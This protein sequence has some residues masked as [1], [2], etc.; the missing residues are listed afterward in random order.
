MRFGVQEHHATRRHWDFRLEMGGVLKSWAIPKG[1][2]YDP[3]EKRLAVPVEDHPLDYLEFEGIIPEGNYGAGTVMVWD[4][5]TY[6]VA[7]GDPVRAYERGKLTLVLHGRKLRGEFHL[8]R[9]KLGGQ[10]QWLMFKKRDA[11]AVPGWTL[12]EP[13]V[14]AKTGRTIEQIRA[15][16]GAQWQSGAHAGMRPPSRQTRRG[17]E[18]ASRLLKD[19][20]LDQPGRDPYPRD[21]KPML[22][23]RVATPFDD[24]QWLFEVKW[25]GVR[26]IAYL[27]AEGPRRDVALRSRGG[28]TLNA[29]FPEVVEA[30]YA[31]DLPAAVLDGEVVALDDG[32][33]ANFQLLQSR[34]H[35]GDDARPRPAPVIAYYVFDLLYFNGH[36]LTDRPL[37]ERRKILQAVLRGGSTVRLSDAIPAN[38]RALYAAAQDLGVEG[39]VAK[40]ADSRYEPGI[41][42]RTW[43]KIKVH[44]RMDAVVGGFTRG[45]GARA[46]TFGAVLLGAYTPEGRLQ[47]IGHCGGGFTEADL[48]A[49]TALLLARRDTTCPF[50]QIP[51]TNERATWV[52]PE[53]VIDVE[54][55]GWTNDGLLRVP[56]YKGVRTDKPARE[57]ALESPGTRDRGMA[58][59][60]TTVFRAP[61][62][63]PEARQRDGARRLDPGS[64]EVE[65][66]N[67]DKVFWPERG[68]T[69]GDLIQYYREIAPVIL[70]HLADRPVTLRRFPNG[71]AGE[72]FYQK[73]YPDAPPFAQL[74]SIWTES[75]KKTLAAPVCNNAQ[76]LLWLA[77]LADI[78]IHTW[79]SRISPLRRAERAGRAGTE[80]AASE[81]ALRD[82]VLNRPDY[83]V[84]DIDPYLFPDNKLPQRNGER[85]PDYSRRGFDAAVEAA[86]LLRKVLARLKLEGFVKTSGKTGLHLFVP[87]VRRYTF[88]QTHAF[89]KAVTQY[90]EGLAPTMVTTAWAAEQ[91][92]G[93]VFLDYNQNRLGATLASAYSVRPT[94]EATVSL[95]VAWTELERGLDPLEF[96]IKTVPVLMRK[97][98]DPWRELLARPQLLERHL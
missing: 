16:A 96:T 57:V 7:E 62:P 78:E 81:Q 64:R 19:L 93:K 22:A 41:R 23:T 33:R 8:V 69:K 54:Y 20:K 45:R 27:R 25:D 46:K 85:D 56:V 75:G 38:G 4:L 68:Y 14:S 66:T 31:Q 1:P 80:F 9:T 89:A 55:A 37:E 87:I 95:P 72:S 52:R 47:Y 42:T 11:D 6:E 26:A 71:I 43:L 39:I 3:A 74:V 82:S 36:R 91:R 58:G 86:L 76:T 97:R 18:R 12:P 67:L 21:L 98:N 73:D 53:L 2:T 63:T 59:P 61:R 50:A 28:M 92:V 90:V 88:E 60:R 70:P 10:V 34:L 48:D 94:P 84:F 44:Q 24:P 51:P 17:P 77:Q 15:E 29:Q 49:M 35:A 32:G 5:G 30:L 13:S 65:F 40:R 83:L 79:F